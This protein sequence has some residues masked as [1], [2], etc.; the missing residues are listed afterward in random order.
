MPPFVRV[1]DEA[2][3]RERVLEKIAVPPLFA[4]DA[5]VAGPAPGIEAV[6]AGAHIQ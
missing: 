6:E 3:G 1:D 2:D 4:D 5:G